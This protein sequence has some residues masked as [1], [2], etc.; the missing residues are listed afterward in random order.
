MKAKKKEEEA[1]WE[2]YR[3][4]FAASTPQGD[5]DL[6][7]ENAT[8]DDQGRKH[9]PFMDYEILDVDMERIIKEVIKEYKVAPKYRAEAFRMS[10]LLGASPKTKQTE[11]K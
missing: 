11:N 9:I 10:V 6:M 8:I 1:L 5:F 7:V 3:R 2:C 4:L